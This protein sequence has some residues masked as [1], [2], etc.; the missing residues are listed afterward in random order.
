MVI[1]VFIEIPKNSNVKY[2]Y[3]RKTNSINVDRILYGSEVYPHNY[4][5][6]PNTL[7]YDGDELDCFVIS[8]H[9]FNPGTFVKARILGAFEMI[10]G[11]EY[12]TKLITVIDCDPRFE[13]IKSL[14]DLSQHTLDEIKNFF[15]NY[16]ILQ[17]KSVVVKDFHDAEW[18]L[19]EFEETQKLFEQYHAIDKKEFVKKM[20]SLHPEKYQL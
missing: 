17:K 19:K 20:Q 9:S 4:G 3:D 14:K 15:Q 5:F 16:K 13:N 1:N 11:G 6:I 7:D 2:E 12:D 18:A 8:N 10:D